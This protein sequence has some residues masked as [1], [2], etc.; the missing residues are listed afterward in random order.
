MANKNVNEMPYSVRRKIC[1]ILDV[2]Q[3]WK[4]LAEE[5]GLS[6]D[7]IQTLELV[8]YRPS[9]SPT[10]DLLT[11]W[12]HSNAS[13]E[14][15]CLF[16]LKLKLRRAAEMLRGIVPDEMF[17]TDA[18]SSNTNN[19]NFKT[20]PEQR[21]LP[22]PS[23]A[24]TELDLPLP[25]CLL[26]N[27]AHDD[28]P[29]K[30][31]TER[32]SCSKLQDWEPKKMNITI[33]TTD[34]SKTCQ[35]S[36][37]FGKN[38]RPL[39]TCSENLGSADVF[40][41]PISTRKPSQCLQSK[42][43]SS[44][45]RV[46]VESQDVP[47]LP[48]KSSSSSNYKAAEFMDLSCFMICY[49]YVDIVAATNTFR[50]DNLLGRG[51]F[52]VVYRGNIKKTTFAIKILHKRENPVSSR[53]F[54]AEINSL[55]KYRQK[56]IIMLSGC[57]ID[58]PA[59]CL[60]YE[61]M[62][63]GSL[64]DRLD[65][66]NNTKP[67][68]WMIRHSVLKDASAG[69][70][71]LHTVDVKPLIHG[72]IKTANIL[73]G[74][75]FE[76]KI[77]DFGLAK[78]A[79]GGTVTGKLTHVTRSEFEK[80]YGSRAYLPEEFFTGGFQ[81][82]IKTDT[83]SFGIVIFETCTGE[84]PD[85][86]R[87]EGGRLLN[88]YVRNVMVNNKNQLLT[89]RDKTSPGWPNELWL[90]VMSLGV[91]CTSETKKQRPLMTEV[92]G[93]LETLHQEMQLK[94]KVCGKPI[95][96][97]DRSCSQPPSF[98]ASEKSYHLSHQSVA[99]PD[100]SLTAGNMMMEEKLS[101]IELQKAYDKSKQRSDRTVSSIHSPPVQNTSSPIYACDPK[102]LREIEEDF[103]ELSIGEDGSKKGSTASQTS[104]RHAVVSDDRENEK[105]VKYLEVETHSYK[106]D[107]SSGLDFN[108]WKANAKQES[109]LGDG[110][111]VSFPSECLENIANEKKECMIPEN[112]FLAWKENHQVGENCLS[113]PSVYQD[114][115]I[116]SEELA[117]IKQKKLPGEFDDYYND[118]DV[119]KDYDSE[120]EE[121]NEERHIISQ[122][123]DT[124]LALHYSSY[125]TFNPVLDIQFV[126]PATDES[127]K[128]NDS[129]DEEN[130]ES[131]S[132][133]RQPVIAREDLLRAEKLERLRKLRHEP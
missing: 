18:G 46:P 78:E 93:R 105:S 3:Q 42:E 84:K 131:K 50:E 34:M 19:K 4:P 128:E 43:S 74:P 103:A 57:S 32:D 7:K 95:G 53:D 79:T 71:Y 36:T 6:V 22:T 17:N 108:N 91:E 98:S 107:S 115:M 12:S 37:P 114:Q 51:G 104:V 67:L 83:Y 45:A 70:Q 92:Y 102:K 33:P 130:E 60:V 20:E 63:N 14:M 122:P 86:A 81:F 23:Q 117:H 72:D 118:E 96:S 113:S 16:L 127:W 30:G 9:Q 125:P 35:R 94:H 85:D 129:A 2:Q 101:P 58:G 13:V 31:T 26:N 55:L 65:C 119:D 109:F 64:Q 41:P 133:S 10:S 44:N 89:I 56:N 124:S 116:L 15:L 21:S 38:S 5:I 47:E 69:L 121:D 100:H 29:Y 75:H 132:S 59:V 52:G 80:V 49:R 123:S 111:S 25:S 68:P 73:L 62:V 28:K 97:D 77:S 99:S 88:E 61:F 87:R 76:A 82:N 120:Q 66:K 24:V 40:F 126:P 48:I 39:D 90:E 11:Y 106:P 27:G 1:E 8:Y 54:L 110:S 112:S